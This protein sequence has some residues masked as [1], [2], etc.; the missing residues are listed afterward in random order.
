ME[1]GTYKHSLDRRKKISK[2][3]MGRIPWNKGKKLPQFSRENHGRWNGGKRRRDNGYSQIL[4][5]E[6]P[7]AHKDG[8]IQEHILVWE[9]YYKQSLPE[10]WLIHHL[11]GIKN[12]NRIEN[13]LAMPREKHSHWLIIQTLQE[14]IKEL[15][16]E[17]KG[18]IGRRK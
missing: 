16:E 10:K 9:S 14:R 17:K 1:T 3:C 12:D 15:E 4:M 13:L 11:N 6:H 5:P 18:P 2:A 8:Y 7:R